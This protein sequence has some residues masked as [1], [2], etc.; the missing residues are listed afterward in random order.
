MCLLSIFLFG[1]KS[2][3]ISVLLSFINC[4]FQPLFQKLIPLSFLF[5]LKMIIPEL[6][7]AI[8]IVEFFITKLLTRKIKHASVYIVKAMIITV[9]SRYSVDFSPKD[10]LHEKGSDRALSQR[11]VVSTPVSPQS[12]RTCVR[13]PD[14]FKKIIVISGC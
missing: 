1:R 11:S 9:T 5:F 8:V 3:P 6:L 14:I 2:Y 12:R 4:L 7:R 13:S 10:I